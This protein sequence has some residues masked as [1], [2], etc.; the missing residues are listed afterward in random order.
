MSETVSLGILDRL[1]SKES[2]TT[3]FLAYGLRGCVSKNS[4]RFPNGAIIGEMKE[5]S[6]RL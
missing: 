4:D 2:S 1:G 6:S 3:P 5:K